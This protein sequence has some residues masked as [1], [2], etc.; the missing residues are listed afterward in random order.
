[1]DDLRGTYEEH[2]W[3]EILTG[4]YYDL[5]QY[6]YEQNF[7]RRAEKHDS[8]AASDDEPLELGSVRGDQGRSIKALFRAAN[9]T[10]SVMLRAIDYCPPVDLRYDEYARALLRADEVAYPFDSSGIREKLREIFGKRGL[11]PPPE[12][13][14]ERADIAYA[15]R[16]AK[17]IDT[18]TATAAD[19]YRF[20]DEYRNLFRIPYEVNFSVSSVYRTNK[21]AKSGYRPP[22]ERVIEFTWKE[23]VELKARSFGSMQGKLLPLYCGGTLVFDEGGNLLHMT[24]VLP[25]DER[26]QSLLEYARHLQGTGSIGFAS[27]KTGSDA[28]ATGNPRIFATVEGDQLR[29]RR[30]A[31][32]RHVR[33]GAA[34]ANS[35]SP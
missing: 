28:P 7:Q 21:R 23:D 1:M 22:K 25:T 20:L 34:A 14:R 31:A 5:L 13:R 10:A 30:N 29:L 4:I 24:L 3:S 35:A 27:G 18:I 33:P 17:D 8:S 19:A 16:H 9:Q 32:M 6:L 2:D 26:R 12:Q 15:L 11:R